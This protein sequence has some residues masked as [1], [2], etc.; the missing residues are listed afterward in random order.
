M[1]RNVKFSLEHFS[2]LFVLLLDTRSIEV[3][4]RVFFVVKRNL[5]SLG[6]IIL[7]VDWHHWHVCAHFRQ[8]WHLLGV[9]VDCFCIFRFFAHLLLTWPWPFHGFVRVFSSLVIRSNVTLVLLL[10]L[11]VRRNLLCC[12]RACLNLHF[13]VYVSAVVQFGRLVASISPLAINYE[14]VEI[15]SLLKRVVKIKLVPFP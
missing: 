5:V 6:E 8:V 15:F 2:Q 12:F 4:P 9:V 11:G 1:G 10:F 7:E 14:L 13:I 3:R